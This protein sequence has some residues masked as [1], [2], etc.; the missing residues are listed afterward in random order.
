MNQTFTKCFRITDISEEEVE[1]VLHDK[2][3]PFAGLHDIKENSAQTLGADV[4]FLKRGFGNEVSPNMTFNEYIDFD[5]EVNTTHGKYTNEEILTEVN[6]VVEED[7][8]DEQNEYDDGEPVTKSGIDVQIV[9]I[10]EDF[11]LLS[12][13]NKAMLKAL[14]YISCSRDK[15]ELCNK[16]QTF[17]SDFLFFFKTIDSEI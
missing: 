8:D 2:D 11:S 9:Q 15:A 6:E 7:S 16:K 3:K 1:G 4:S 13:F 5:I 10:L 14:K 12:H 17:I